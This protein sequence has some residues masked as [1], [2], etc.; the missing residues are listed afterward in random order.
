MTTVAHKDLTG[1]DL[2]EPKGVSTAGTGTV[3][4]ANGSGSGAWTSTA[5]LSARVTG[6]LVPFI[7]PIAPSG[8]LEADGSNVSRSTYADLFAAVTIQQTGTKTSGNT[9]VTG[10]SDTTN[11][12]VGY[13]VGGTGITNGTTLSAVPSSTTL[14][15]SANATATGSGTVIVSPWP[16]G[17]GSTTFTLPDMKT[18]GR[19]PRSRTSSVQMGTYQS[20]Q[21]KTHTH[22]FTT[23]SDGGQ[24]ITTGTE[25]AD[26]VHGVKVSNPTLF[27][28]AGASTVSILTPGAGITFNSEGKSA[29]HTHSVTTSS[30]I[31]SGTTDDG[32]LGTET[33]PETIVV[34]WCVKT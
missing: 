3:Y 25:S 13:Y 22:G 30:H 32:S 27:Y 18:T 14:T 9:G 28:Q 34:L 11:M 15:L 21:I 4:V 6:E 20:N 1:A 8:W 19:F 10:L 31:H 2:H 23:S 24:T 5:S 17:N 12:K 26:H 7:I 29:T 33:R 16:L